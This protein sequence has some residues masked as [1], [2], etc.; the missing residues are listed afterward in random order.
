[1]LELEIDHTASF[2]RLFALELVSTRA[3]ELIF[4][5][6]ILSLYRATSRIAHVSRFGKSGVSLDKSGWLDDAVITP[7]SIF[8]IPS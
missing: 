2:L 6:P 5:L 3:I 7:D 4:Q 1:M 8:Q